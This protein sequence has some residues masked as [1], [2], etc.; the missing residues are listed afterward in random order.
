MTVTDAADQRHMARCLALARGFVRSKIHNQRVLLRRNG[1]PEEGD[2]VRLKDLAE[3]VDQAADLAHLLGVEGEAAAIYFRR[4]NTMIRVEAPLRDTFS[5]ETRNRRPPRDP[6]NCLLSFAY[7][8]LVRELTATLHGIGLDPYIGFLHQ[9]RFGRPALSLDLME[10]FRP[11]LA[12]SAVLTAIN[13]GEVGP[14]D[15]LVHPTGCALTADGK[16]A[17]VRA[18]ERR[19]DD[20]ATHPVFQ[21]K[22]SYRRILELQARGLS[23]VLMGEL[24][25]WPEYRVR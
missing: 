18:I 14:N 19:L 13:K 22:L 9:P 3:Q 16:R 6:V 4:F 20:V 7:A 8:V 1:A 11:V 21:T 2:L 5:F 17:F 24:A 12:D 15:F 23:K 10:E 25:A